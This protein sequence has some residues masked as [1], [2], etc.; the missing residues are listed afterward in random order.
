[1]GSARTNHAR[2]LVYKKNL[3]YSVLRFLDSLWFMK[4]FRKYAVEFLDVKPKQKVLDAG[5]GN[6]IL[7]VLVKKMHADADVHAVDASKY[8]IDI[9]VKNAKKQNL[10]IKFA[11]APIE[12]IPFKKNYFDRILCSL[13]L[14]HIAHENRMQ[15]LKELKR[16]LKPGGRML[17]VDIG[18][19]SNIFSSLILW[20]I[21]K[22]AGK[23]EEH[24]AKDYSEGRLTG[25]IKYIKRAGFR[26]V[27]LA[28]KKFGFVDFL[29]AE[30]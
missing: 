5:C 9:A 11:T 30:K 4:N 23:E 16:V 12:K 3:E 2:D 22:F 8:G 18:K 1:M 26:N 15:A 13:V 25:Y 19:R 24:L 21:L 17:I 14:H 10:Q 28:G 29:T 20:I 6:G 7:S 27:R